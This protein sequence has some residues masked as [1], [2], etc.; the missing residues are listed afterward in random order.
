[1]TA[2]QSDTRED[3]KT[4][5]DEYGKALEGEGAK[6]FNRSIPYWE[7]AYR[8]GAIVSDADARRDRPRPVGLHQERRSRPRRRSTATAAA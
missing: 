6:G 3:L 7:P 2:L 4:L 1:M 8:D 5:L